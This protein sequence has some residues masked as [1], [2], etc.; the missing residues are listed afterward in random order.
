MS[1][2]NRSGIALL[3]LL[4]VSPHLYAESKSAPLPALTETR[5]VSSLDGEEQA[6]LYWAPD[7][8]RTE[9]VPMLVFLP[10]CMR[11]VPVLNGRLE[12]NH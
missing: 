8:A 1:A 9:S 4:V 10:V 6:V 2:A 5:V 3:L 11:H 7:N 12:V